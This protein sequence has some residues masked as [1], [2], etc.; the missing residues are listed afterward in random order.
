MDIDRINIYKQRIEKF[1]KEQDLIRRELSGISVARLLLFLVSAW[2]LYSAFKARFTGH[3]LLYAVLTV[4]VFI[5][6]VL[7]A[8][9]KKGKYKFLQQ[10]IFINQNEI[11][12]NNGTKSFL[13]DGHQ[14][15][16][17]KGFAVDL[18]LF[19]KDSLFQLINRAGSLPGKEQIAKRF[20][21]PF[22]DLKNISDYQGAAKELATKLT[23][24]QE[25][26]ARTLLL[27][28]E[29]ALPQLKAGIPLWQFSVI[30]KGT[31]N[32][33][34]T[35]WP[36]AGIVVTV[37][38][39][40]A[41]N[42]RLMLLFGILGLFLL[43]FVFRKVN[44]LYNHISKRSYLYNQY[45]QCFRLI[46]NEKFDDPFLI[47]KQQEI[48]QAA[49]AFKHLSK[50]IGLFDLRMSLFSFVLNGLFLLDLLCSRAY[51]KWN[52]QYQPQIPGWFDTLGEIE[53]LNS[54]ATFHFNHTS[55]IFPQAATGNLS[56]EA[57]AMGHPLMN[58]TKAVVN[59]LSIG[60]H[61]KLHIITG[62][63]MSGKSTYL[64]TLGLNMVLAQTGAPVF[65]QKFVFSP[66]QILTSF[67]HID[68]L[69]E[70][71]SYF[72][73]ELRALQSIIQSLDGPIPSLVLLDEV[74]RGTNSKDKHDGTALLIKKIL[75]YPC[76]TLIATHDTELGILANAHPGAVENFCFESELTADG[77]HF[78]F[79]KR[80]GVAQS[81]NAT[82]LMQK[83]GII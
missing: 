38:S 83:M 26:L 29:E 23:F 77:L 33:I 72:Y 25:M 15:A 40:W 12:I 32:V 78:D 18:G 22:L 69:S 7:Y 13:N 30:E 11:D 36:L 10:L 49:D 52:K 28:E 82:Y 5:L 3:D 31:W 35:V 47:K 70:S 76:L 44:K 54:I 2:F 71:T 80:N 16:P 63:N 51:I 53:L 1:T 37:Y 62:S 61:S 21:D 8:G 4:P 27:E 81:T 65:A 24:R 56:I 39:I 19:G 58:E 75:G 67:H 6:L 74:M 45:A 48:N 68:S 20:S 14:Y 9:R 42:Y 57:V 66:V 59:D 79:K 60:T 41:D 50:L 73:A 46:G 55:F 64:R 34:A 43:S 17:D